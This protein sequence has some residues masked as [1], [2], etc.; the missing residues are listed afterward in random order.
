[1]PDTNKLNEI[2][3]ELTGFTSLHGFS[4][5]LNTSNPFVKVLWIFFF[6]ILFSGCIQNVFENIND[7]YQY[8]VITKIEYVNE[9]PMALPALTLCLDTFLSS[10][11][12]VTLNDYLLNCSIGAVECDTKDFYSFEIRESFSNELLVCY[13]LNGGR[14]S[15]GP[16][17]KIKSSRTTG[18]LSGFFLQFYVPNNHLFCITLTMQM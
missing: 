16:V 13:V 17:S 3:K 12:D 11:T 18:I 14:N 2:K 6:L 10:S 9:Y 4:T 15:T 8:T 1:V 5:V 7:Y